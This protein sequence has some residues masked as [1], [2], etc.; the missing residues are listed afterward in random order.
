MSVSSN[1]S[2]LTSGMKSDTGPG[3]HPVTIGGEEV[4]VEVSSV[5]D[6]FADDEFLDDNDEES[7]LF[8]VGS[9]EDVPGASLDISAA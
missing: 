2:L 4:D 8:L 9:E 3:V 1:D 6:A 5:D 7:L